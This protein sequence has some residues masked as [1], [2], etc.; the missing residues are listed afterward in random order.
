MP[1]DIE[2]S[3]R[4]SKYSDGK[5]L[6]LK[7][8]VTLRPFISSTL[9]LPYGEVMHIAARNADDGDYASISFSS[10][11]NMERNFQI[12]IISPDTFATAKNNV[13]LTF[14]LYPS[15]AVGCDNLL[16]LRTIPHI[17]LH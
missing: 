7:V 15:S 10:L 4:T 12:T 8:T 1:N 3:E 17:N 11:K 5:K 13:N 2:R 9:Y 14:A 6:N 16:T